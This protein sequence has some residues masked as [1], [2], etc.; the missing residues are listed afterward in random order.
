MTV[1]ENISA[2]G[3]SAYWRGWRLR[4]SEE[5]RDAL[6]AMGSFLVRA[7]SDQVPLATLSGGN[8]QKVVLARW[9]RRAPRVLLLDE[10]TQGVDV[11]ARQEIY[12]LIRRSAADGAAVILVANDFA[13]LAR[14]C[15][16][17]VVLRQGRVVGEV[18]APAIDSHRLT[19][20]AYRTE[21]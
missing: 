15:G 1:R 18:V 4:H 14:L 5:R 12:D 10:P 21:D 6:A 19:E 11:G 3:V 17:V 20:L 9:L 8:Q 13:E 7:P 2:G 16:R